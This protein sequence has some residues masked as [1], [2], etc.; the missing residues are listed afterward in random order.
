MAGHSFH[1]GGFASKSREHGRNSRLALLASLMDPAISPAAFKEALIVLC[2]AGI[3]IPLFHRIRL[4]PVLGFMLIGAIVGPFGLGRAA[5]TVSWLSSWLGAVT[6]PDPTAIEPIARFGV[7][8]LL[9][10]IGLELSFERLWLMR[11]LVFG[12][13][14]LQLAVCAALL[15]GV[16]LLV[17]NIAPAAAVLGV[18]GAMS[19][20]AVVL[21]VLAADKKL[22]SA[23]GR[24]S[25]AMLLFQDL[26]VIPVLF[27][28][29]LLAPRSHGASLAGFALAIGQAV[30]AVTAVIAF[31]RV[32][33]RPLFRS[34]A[35]TRSPELFM[36]A[37][38]L[39]VIAAALATASAGL[40]MA[41]GALIGGL[42]LAG[43]E[44]RR[45]VEVTIDPFKGLLVGVF[46]I[47]VGLGLDLG[48]V[49]AHPLSIF[50]AVTAL[51]VVKL[52]AVA[53]LARL[54]GVSW[55]TGAQAGL[56]LAP[57]GEFSFVILAITVPEGFLPRAIAD[58]ALIA[59]ALTMIGTPLLAMLGDRIT[60]SK[61]Q[62]PVDPALL[63]PVST[64]AK[65]R[66][67]IAGFGRVG[68]TVAAMLE[69]HRIPY[70]AID[71]DPDHVAQ[72]RA[73]GR[74]VFY[75]DMT[76]I[77]LLR[78]LDLDTAHA[79]VVTMDDR[80]AADELVTTA[81]G[82]TRPAHRRPR[83][84]RCPRCSSVS[85]GGVGRGAR[86]SRG[87]PATLRGGAG[88][89][90]RADGAGDRVHPRETRRASGKH[91]S[92]GAQGRDTPDWPAPAARRRV[93]K[94]GVA[95]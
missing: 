22:G 86:D 37:C 28:L 43:T 71:R 27:A 94:R 56:L 52:G 40:S 62:P 15:A 34:V 73:E 69:V 77:E 80:R 76:Q 25:F 30:V 75:G 29:S 88:R 70:V 16:A 91:Q 89:F 72:R 82:T 45:Q 49:V 51:L 24:V 39:V 47:S 87:R 13:G 85:G 48:L 17:G 33:L 46:L 10:M 65:P 4:S 68:Q 8:L 83:P 93:A 57:G 63:V 18:A 21:Q 26:A 1:G 36:A 55:R 95:L 14:A 67:L 53:V 9:F 2:A 84:R 50:G 19:S 54:F 64:A 44:F 32:A 78:R 59:V 12:L 61:T 5:A 42:L 7:V 35:R 41:L 6:I 66:V 3:V 79:L 11:R 92:D 90:G 20:T 74:P 31:G 38:L 23:V 60:P 81:R 58:Q